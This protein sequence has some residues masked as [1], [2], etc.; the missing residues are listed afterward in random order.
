MKKIKLFSFIVIMFSLFLIN[1]SADSCTE[2][3]EAGTPCGRC[4][5]SCV[6]NAEGVCV[7]N[8]NFGVSEEEKQKNQKLGGCSE[9]TFEESCEHNKFYSCIWNDKNPYGDPY[10]N[11]DKLIYVQCGDT[12]DIP[13]QAP[14]VISF[15]VNLLK[16]ATPIILIIV[17][18]IALLKAVSASNEDEIKKAQKG[19]IRKVIAAVMVFFVI[20]IV[21]FVIMKVADNTVK[22]TD[23]KTEADNLSTCLSCFLNNDCGN[24]AYYK[25]N[26]FGKYKCTYFNDK[27][28]PVDCKGDE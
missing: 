12:F 20:S 1:V 19:L 17:S 3:N 22:N 10:C 7:V 4:G 27:D 28:N 25:T 11:T 23:N 18:I 9:Y 16:I 21:Q 13:Y 24:N 5:Y 2:C 26:V 6:V 8:T 14:Q 15:F